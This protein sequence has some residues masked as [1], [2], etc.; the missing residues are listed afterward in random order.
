MASHQGVE[1][2]GGR[3][4]YTF[5]NNTVNSAVSNDV[6]SK[7]FD[8]LPP[9]AETQTIIDNRLM[10]GNY[11]DGFDNV[12]LEATL[13]AQPSE[14]PVDF[15]EYEVKVIPSVSPSPE[16]YEGGAQNKNIGFTIDASTL[17][18]VIPAGSFLSFS[19]PSTP[20]RT[21]TYTTRRVVITSLLRWVMIS[22]MTAGLEWE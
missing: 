11:V 10:Y 13:A 16:D 5:L 21:F 17:D 2:R 9:K 1:V 3:L 4:S 20:S 12:E 22:P 8:N 7:Q 6:Q 18:S 14:R 19:S 15:V